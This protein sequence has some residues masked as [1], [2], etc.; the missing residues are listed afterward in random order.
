MLDRNRSLKRLR[1]P[2]LSGVRCIRL[3][4]KLGF[5]IKPGATLIAF[6][7][8]LTKPRKRFR[9]FTGNENWLENTTRKIA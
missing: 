7:E 3:K 6:N 4:E 5:K 9:L 1:R 8:G 2:N